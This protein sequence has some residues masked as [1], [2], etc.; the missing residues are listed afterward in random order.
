[1]GN[2]KMRICIIDSGIDLDN[3]NI[4]KKNIHLAYKG[5]YSDFHDYLG[6][7]TNCCDLIQKLYPAAQI[8]IIKIFDKKAITTSKSI[9]DSIEWCINNKIEII[10]LCASVVDLKYFD[11]FNNI[12]EKAHKRKIFIIASADNFQRPCLPA[13][14]KNVIGVGIAP[15]IEKDDEFYYIKDFNIQMYAKGNIPFD[16][17]KKATS[18]ATARATGIIAN[19]IYKYPNSNYTTLENILQAA[20]K[21]IFKPYNR[22][23]QT[24]PEWF[25]SN[26]P[27]YKNDKFE[28]ITTFNDSIFVGSSYEVALIK[29]YDNLLKINIS[30]F[31]TIDITYLNNYDVESKEKKIN[32]Y[33]QEI[34]QKLGGVN[35]L[36]TGSIPKELEHLLKKECKKANKTFFTLYNN[37]V[38]LR[39]DIKM[40]NN[41]LK[42]NYN[43]FFFNKRTPVISIINLTDNCYNTINIDIQ[44]REK[45]LRSK[46]PYKHITSNPLGLF[47][48]FDYN[49][50]LYKNINDEYIIKYTQNILSANNAKIDFSFI[51]ASIDSK[52]LPDMNLECMNNAF[53]QIKG[54]FVL[55]GLQPDLFIFVIDELT[56]IEYI[57]R[58]LY[59]AKGLCNS[60]NVALIFSSSFHF[61]EPQE[62]DKIFSSRMIEMIKE[63]SLQQKQNI[64][65]T[66]SHLYIFDIHDDI[67]KIIRYILKSAKE[68]L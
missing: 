2:K 34:L 8:F 45:L 42:T 32:Y 48:D 59:L 55:F 37:N 56:T 9:I 36:V 27:V 46:T 22:F 26:N 30:Y 38:L 10:N 65:E 60:G 3:P 64:N 53:L 39:K 31:Y 63:K 50:F 20:S 15:H 13:Y 7:G 11:E 18:F 49:L 41:R 12:C 23:I 67:E 57:K 58:N 43:N 17:K 28:F 14:L 52:I 16:S 62:K 33:F 35:S 1:M 40:I 61:I 29:D 44:I 5:Q 66:F 68:Q 24:N 25:L 51:I 6:H 47:F 21:K 54:I 19:Y 4:I